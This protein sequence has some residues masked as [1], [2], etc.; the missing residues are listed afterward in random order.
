MNKIVEMDNL[1]HS[2]SNLII[3]GPSYSGKSTIVRLII[4]GNAQLYTQPVKAVLY[5]HGVDDETFLESLSTDLVTPHRGMPSMTTIDEFIALHNGAHVLCIFDD[6]SIELMSN[7]DN[8]KLFCTKSHHG[9]CSMILV[10]HQLFYRNK[11]A[12]LI[13]MSSHY[14]ILTRNLRDVSTISHLARQLFPKKSQALIECYQ[15]AME[16]KLDKDPTV[17]PLLLICFHPLYSDREYMLFSD[18]LPAGGVKV[19]YKL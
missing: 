9:N 14:L 1:L 2:P 12:R 19:V 18:F 6:L 17:P 4:E 13:T 15:S 5:C 16:D 8:Y 10:L 3:G 11:I 7:D